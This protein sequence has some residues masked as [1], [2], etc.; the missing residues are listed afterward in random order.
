MRHFLKESFVANEEYQGAGGRDA[1]D[2]SLA[3]ILADNT[4]GKDLL[5]VEGAGLGTGM[6]PIHEDDDCAN[7]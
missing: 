3:R 1:L 7:R 2:A 6:V 4:L 5:Q